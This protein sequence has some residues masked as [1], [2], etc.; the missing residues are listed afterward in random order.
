LELIGYLKITNEKENERNKYYPKGSC[1]LVSKGGDA[2]VDANHSF[3]HEANE[4]K[5]VLASEL[6]YV[7]HNWNEAKAQVVEFAHNYR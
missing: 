2:K 5:F 1:I 3:R 4:S 7:H 6:V